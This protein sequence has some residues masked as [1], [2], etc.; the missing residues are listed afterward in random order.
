[1]PLGVR[2]AT[3]DEIAAAQPARVTAASFAA[4][5]AARIDPAAR[6]GLAAR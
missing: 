6:T 3:P 1:M 4:T 2:V 5:V